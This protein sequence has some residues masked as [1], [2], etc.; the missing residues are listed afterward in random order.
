M[1]NQFIGR[2]RDFD[3]DAI[4]TSVNLQD[5]SVQADAVSMGLEFNK[6]SAGAEGGQ[7]FKDELLSDTRVAANSPEAQGALRIVFEMTDSVSGRA[8]REFLP[9]PSLSKAQDVGTNPAYIVS[10][11]LTML[12]PVHA[13]YI[14]TKAVLDAHWQSPEGNAGTL[15]RAFIEE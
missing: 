4:Q 10:G 12:N 15:S 3:N 9:I 8:Y 6:W 1:P 7:Y 14:S 11:G 5:S 13:D 2:Y